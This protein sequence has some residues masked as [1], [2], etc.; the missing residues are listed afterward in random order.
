MDNQTAPK[1]LTKRVI[2]IILGVI[3]LAEVLWA[4]WSL[5][6]TTNESSV[7]APSVVTQPKSTVVTLETPKQAVKVGE[8]FTVSIRIS[9]DKLTDGTDLIITYD[10]KLLSVET[11]GADKTPVILG[12]LYSDY[13]LNKLDLSLGKIT[14]SGVTTQ[15]GGVKADGLFGSIVFTATAAGV[16][17]VSLDFSPGKTADSNVTE[18]G[19]GKDVLEKVENLEVNI[20]P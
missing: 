7:S 20:N 11:V 12:T 15:K 3:I 10:P 16:T 6:K 19:T 8:K 13:P 2:F 14:V 5:F 17:Q 1:F 4:G 18:T 9:S